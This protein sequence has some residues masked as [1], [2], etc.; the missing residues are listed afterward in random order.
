[1]M[2]TF[3]VIGRLSVFLVLCGT[4]LCLLQAQAV[5]FKFSS[6]GYHPQGAKLAVV[7]DVPEDK[8]MSIVLYDPTRRNPKF[9]VL[10]GATVYKIENVKT[11]QDLNQQG[12]STKKLLLDFSAFQTPGTY[13]LRIEG[14]DIKSE[15]IKINE[16]LYWD[17]MKPI[18]RS[19]YFQ[20]CGQEVEDKGLNLFHSACH[21]KDA[22][23]ANTSRALSDDDSLDVVG[24]WHNGGDY[25]K[26]VTST[27]LSAARLMAMD[28]W[29]AKPFKFFRMD[30]PLYEP[31]YGAT[32]DLHHEIKAGLDWIMVMQRRD[33][34]LYR[35]VAG[36]KWPGNVSPEEDDQ[37]RYVYGITTQDTANAAAALA[38][39]ARDFKSADLGYS[40]KS[41]MAAE[42]AWSFLE[43]RSDMII[44]HSDSDVSG[45][46]EFIDPK[47]TTD[48]PYRLW[49]AAE[50]Y[51]STGKDKYHDYFR[52]HL[53]QVPLQKFSWM[54]P[55]MQGAVDYLLYAKS[56]DPKTVDVL[57]QAVLRV[58]DAVESNVDADAYSVGLPKYGASSNQEIAERGIVLMDAYRLTGKTEYRD[59]ASRL[60]SYFFG[61]NPLGMTYVTG[62]A[63]KSVSH[64]THRWMQ[65]SSKLIPGYV[66]DGPNEAATDGKT[67]QGQ[68]VSSYVDD[69]AAK[70]VN[71]SKLLNN[72]SLACLLAL[73]NDS[74]NVS[75]NEE[76]A[77]PKT[78]LDF[79]L[80]PERPKKK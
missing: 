33:G 32:D 68:G 43:S 67:P 66:V 71:E 30:Y 70:S 5:T 27:A 9:P 78:P 42:K 50:L 44:Q 25:A 76:Q 48:T 29:N 62:F 46:G 6:I 26:Y 64:P 36:K 14:T 31:G 74:Y 69:A 79:Q 61:V 65:A 17:A 12:P 47:A 3:K 39:A 59:A 22:Q 56:P 8:K 13:E 10:L 7:E 53:T 57:K 1:M 45:S 24:G 73:L 60:V 58:A 2:K 21:L 51:V 54:N 72:A 75:A 11:V 15:P 34:S 49:A 55:V 63:G 18:V 35:K 52:Q 20:R 41:L 38:M 77:G 37:P 40:V 4:S 23:Y 80:A 28:E 19:F 16:F